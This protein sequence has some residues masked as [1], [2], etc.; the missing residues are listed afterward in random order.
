MPN[1]ADGSIWGSTIGY[2][3]AVVR[4]D[5]GSNPPE[6]AL[7]EVYT[8]PMP[9]Y[10][11]RGG[12]IDSNGVVWVSMGSGHLG[13]FDRRKCKG[14]LNGP[15]AATGR[16]CPE[17]WKL[18]V[19]PGPQ[20]RDV[21]DPGSVESSYYAWV[22]QFDIAGLGRDVPIAT[23]NLNSALLAL[24]DGR[25]VNLRVPY[26]VGFF[27]KWVDG[28]IDDPNA[29]WKG[30]GLWTTYSTRAMFHL[31]GGKENRPKVVKFQIRPDPLAK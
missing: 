17:G 16:H 19:F 10:G 1:P 26:P 18:H 6:T 5:P 14:P 29:G 22:D 25:F 24:V 4:L 12:D 7:A 11:I 3:G 21:A 31:E 28:R 9:G 15:Q 2:P 13:S 27:T 20:F 8:P 30:R 23:G